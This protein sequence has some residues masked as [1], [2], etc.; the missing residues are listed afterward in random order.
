[1]E[2]DPRRRRA[3]RHATLDA[4]CGNVSIQARRFHHVHVGPSTIHEAGYGLFAGEV[5]EKHELVQE[6]VGEVIPQMEAERRGSIYDILNRSYLFDLD[7]DASV[8]ATRKGNKMRFANHS[9]DPNCHARK[10]VV[11][12]C[13]RI[14]IFA[15]RRIRAHEEL[16]FD[17]RYDKEIVHAGRRQVAADV[18]WLKDRKLAGKVYTGARRGGRSAGIAKDGRPKSPRARGT[19]GRSRSDGDDADQGTEDGD[20]AG[21]STDVA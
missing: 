14:G 7:D 18:A 19:G 1:M 3:L 5:I 20:E 13:H 2:P 15:K 16:F 6:Y 9:K 8:D 21:R 10:L 4:L 17:Y 11:N 12:G